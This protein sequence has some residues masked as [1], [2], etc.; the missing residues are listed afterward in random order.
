L[1]L[2]FLGPEPWEGLFCR[3]LQVFANYPYRAVFFIFSM[4]S[5][6]FALHWLAADCRLSLHEKGRKRAKS[7]KID[8]LFTHHCRPQASR[9]RS[10]KPSSNACFDKRSKSGLHF[11]FGGWRLSRDRRIVW[12]HGIPEHPTTRR[13]NPPLIGI[14]FDALPSARHRP[15]TWPVWQFW[16][17]FGSNGRLQS[18]CAFGNDPKTAWPRQTY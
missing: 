10:Y 15:D 7:V 12:F 18:M 3:L 5:R 1:N 9:L 8:S 14:A 13:P 4:T 2:R 17:L 11:Y 16:C 6:V